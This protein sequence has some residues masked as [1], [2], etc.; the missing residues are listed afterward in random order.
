MIFLHPGK[1]YNIQLIIRANH[2]SEPVKETS[3]DDE[4][5]DALD[6][7]GLEL[8]QSYDYTEVEDEDA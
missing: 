6:N 3:V 1:T 2:I 5:A 8:V 7:L 4:L